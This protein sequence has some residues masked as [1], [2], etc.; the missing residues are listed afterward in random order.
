MSNI[1]ISFISEDNYTLTKL[2]TKNGDF[3]ASASMKSVDSFLE[4]KSI[5]A[6][7]GFATYII[8]FMAMYAQQNNKFLV[9]DLEGD[10]REAVLVHFERLYNDITTT[11]KQIPEDLSECFLEF[12]TPEESEFLFKGFSLIPTT[13]FTDHAIFTET[14]LTKKLDITYQDVFCISYDND[15]SDWIDTDYPID[16]VFYHNELF[17]HLFNKNKF[18]KEYQNL[19]K[20]FKFNQIIVDNDIKFALEDIKKKEYSRTH[21]NI[22]CIFDF[23]GRLIMVDGWHRLIQNILLGYKDIAIDILFDERCGEQFF[24][25]FRPNTK[26][27][28]KFNYNKQFLGL[29]VFFNNK[30]LCSI[31]EQFLN[32]KESIGFKVV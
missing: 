26:D 27:L 3:L 1:I 13:F 11:H 10:S 15:S 9:S 29:E 32:D 20:T 17:T 30:V 28:F 23:K 12:T 8:N 14:V 31:R 2:Y 7:K 18:I 24:D 4:L 25:S 6:R 5:V 22:E 21:G 19:T 16:N